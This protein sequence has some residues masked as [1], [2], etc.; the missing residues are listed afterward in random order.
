MNRD[1]ITRRCWD[2]CEA[3][4]GKQNLG[5]DADFYADFYSDPLDHLE[6]IEFVLEEFRII[7]SDDEMY[8]VLTFRDLIDLIERKLPS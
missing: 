3:H 5:E 8:D 4:F 7:A 2:Y 1:E 6:M